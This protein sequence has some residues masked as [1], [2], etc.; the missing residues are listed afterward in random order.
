MSYLKPV[1]GCPAYI[2]YFKEGDSVPPA[3]PGAQGHRE[4]ACGAR[5]QGRAVRAGPADLAGDFQVRLP[6]SSFPLPETLSASRGPP[7]SRD[8][9]PPPRFSAARTGRRRRPG[10][11]KLEAGKLAAGSW[12]REAGS[13]KLEAGSGKLGAGSGKREAGSWKREAGSGSY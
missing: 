7:P 12:K 10:S 8:C 2:E 6:A 11:W 9:S 13:W 3:V 5:G 1:E 4:T